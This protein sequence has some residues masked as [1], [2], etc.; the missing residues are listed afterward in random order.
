MELSPIP[1]T[2]GK[3]IKVALV[4]LGSMGK[5]HFRAVQRSKHFR[6]TAVVDA[7]NKEG[8]SGLLKEEGCL[9]FKIL[10]DLGHVDFDCAIVATPTP[11]HFKLSQELLRREKHLLIEETNYPRRWRSSHSRKIAEGAQMPCSSWSH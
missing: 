9:H 5:H 3:K 2:A 7:L 10:Q 4:G 11:T 6:L 8:E 1:R